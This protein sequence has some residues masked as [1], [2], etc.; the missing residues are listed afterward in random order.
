MS[1]YIQI[2]GIVMI[3]VAA[4]GFVLASLGQIRLTRSIEARLDG[5]DV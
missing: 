2:A 5:N 4:V 3:S 1:Q